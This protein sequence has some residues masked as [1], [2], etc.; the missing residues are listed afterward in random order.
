M[1]QTWSLTHPIING[2]VDDLVSGNVSI[3]LCRLRPAELSD[4]WTD[5][6]KSQT[7]R[8]TRH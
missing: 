5:D 7:A 4:S 3:G 2:C 1:G 8:F 6:V